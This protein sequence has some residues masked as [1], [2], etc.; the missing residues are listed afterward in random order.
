MDQHP[1]PAASTSIASSVAASDSADRPPS[2]A[3]SAS[4][5]KTCGVCAAQSPPRSSVARRRALHFASYEVNA[6]LVLAQ[7]RLIV[8]VTGVAAIA[9]SASGSATSVAITPSISS[10][11]TSGRAASW[12]A[13]S[14][15]PTAA[16][17]VGD[18]LRAGWRRRRPRRGRR[19]RSSWTCPG[20]T[21]DDDRAH[22]PPARK[23]AIDHSTIGLPGQRHEGLRA[24]GSEPLPGAGGRDDRGDGRCGAATRWRRSAPPAARRGTPPRPPRPC[25]ART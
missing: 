25:R 4:T 3:R 20:G 2:A 7:P 24:A 10:G 19:P 15:V 16:E 1:P 17:R 11:V 5:R 23:A 12:I 6:A 22:R 21:G 13:T 14:S 18:R 9:P 8:S